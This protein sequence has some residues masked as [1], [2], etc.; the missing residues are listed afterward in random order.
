M[1]KPLCGDKAIHLRGIKLMADYENPA[2]LFLED[3]SVE[4]LADV[5]AYT[6]FLRKE[7][8]LSS[9]PPINIKNIIDRFGMHAPQAIPLPQQQGTTIPFLGTPQIIIHAGDPASRQKYSIAHELVEL[10]FLELPGGIRPDRLKENIFGIKKERICQKAAG[11]LLMPRDS[12][13]PRA[14]QIGLSFQSA[15]ILADVYEVSLMAALCR[16]TDMYPKQSIFILW[17]LRH[18]PTELKNKV[19][20]TQIEI[21]GFHPTNLPEPKL[22]VAWR[23]GDYK[24]QF[25]PID[26]SVPKDSSVYIAWENN[27][28]SSGAEIIPFGSYNVKAF[29][30]SKPILIN[31]ERHVLS[32]VR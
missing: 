22:R 30:E 16:M 2:K 20:E 3:H 29:I 24:G 25:M 11:N 14:M 18:K 21:P 23:Y 9:D 4:S 6:D 12:F 31:G 28:P 10:L 5:I 19:P 15:E 7:S 26:K 27:Q 13:Y 32:L 17:Q 8:G 1:E